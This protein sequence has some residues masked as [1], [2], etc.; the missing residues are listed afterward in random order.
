MVESLDALPRWSTPKLNTLRMHG[1]KE[2]TERR[3][4][5]EGLGPHLTVDDLIWGI[6]LL[7]PEDTNVV[8]TVHD[9]LIAGVDIGQP[10]A[11]VLLLDVLIL[12]WWLVGL[13]DSS[14]S[15]V[16]LNIGE[17]VDVDGML[18]VESDAAEG[19]AGS[20]GLFGGFVLNESISAKIPL[21]IHALG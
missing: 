6:L 11:E 2:S 5:D 19:L 14:L 9:E 20:K 3:P 12:L 16:T 8:A 4:L 18:L 17:L 7:V 13:V 10:P 21:S 15:S 1:G